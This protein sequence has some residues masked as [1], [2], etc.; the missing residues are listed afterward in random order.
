MKKAE[1]LKQENVPEFIKQIVR[2]ALDDVE[3]SM[4][5]IGVHTHSPK[6]ENDCGDCCGKCEK[7]ED[8]IDISDH[9]ENIADQLITIID[10]CDCEG[11]IKGDYDSVR[12]TL[13]SLGIIQNVVL[14]L[15]AF[16]KDSY[17]EEKR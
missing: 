9:V 8:G 11:K 16:I 1:F 12:K 15:T 7:Y 4:G 17:H 13:L 5:K 14:Q 6:K 3:I 2:N 10:S